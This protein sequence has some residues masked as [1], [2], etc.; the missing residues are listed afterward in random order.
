[1]NSLVDTTLMLVELD[2][3]GVRVWRNKRGWFH[4]SEKALRASGGVRPVPV[5][6]PFET[7][8]EAGTHALKRI[9]REAA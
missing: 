5:H 3:R 1:M 9:A 4:A 6:G 7:A 8:V 2:E